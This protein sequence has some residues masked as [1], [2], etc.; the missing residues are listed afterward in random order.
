MQT[1]LLPLSHALRSAIADGHRRIESTV[2]AREMI[3]G[4]ITRHAYVALLAALAPVHR[5]LDERAA[6]VGCGPVPV[7]LVLRASAVEADLATL[8]GP[9]PAPGPSSRTVARWL[10]GLRHPALVGAA[11][12]VAGSRLGSTV[13]RPLLARSL[14]LAGDAGLR[15]HDGLARDRWSAVCLAI[16]AWEAGDRVRAEVVDGACGMMDGLL[17]VYGESERG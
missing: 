15:A 5:A 12:V 13:L 8:G 7:D 11:Y 9:R 16:D 14:G 3:G 1:C 17:A 4:R 6:V 10:D 2:L